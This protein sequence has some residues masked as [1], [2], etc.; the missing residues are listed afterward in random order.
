MKKHRLTK[1]C[2]RR[3]QYMLRTSRNTFKPADIIVA[4]LR[5]PNNGRHCAIIE[6]TWELTKQFSAFRVRKLSF[7]PLPPGVPPPHC[8]VDG[9]NRLLTRMIGIN[10][11]FLRSS[12]I[13]HS[14]SVHMSP[15]EPY[16]CRQ[17][18]CC[19]ESHV[20]GAT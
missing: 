18:L 12:L 7:S 4:L 3:W 1:E 6:F 13:P 16:L 5:D 11:C 20:C 19:I 15:S 8:P 14:S 9:S 17:S 2:V 10:L